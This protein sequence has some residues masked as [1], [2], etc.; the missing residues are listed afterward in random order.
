MRH[1]SSL[2][3]QTNEGELKITR[4][5]AERMKRRAITVEQVIATINSPHRKK[6]IIEKKDVFHFYGQKNKRLSSPTMTCRYEVVVD[7]ASKT[8]I[9]VMDGNSRLKAN[10]RKT[11]KNKIVKNLKRKNGSG[12]R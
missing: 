1:L 2:T 11:I 10:R 3:I 5:A 8:V 7:L 6:P 4:H 12:K 9:T